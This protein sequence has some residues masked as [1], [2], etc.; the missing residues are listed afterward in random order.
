MKRNAELATRVMRALALSP[1]R[2]HLL[3][4]SA[5][6]APIVVA[7]PN[8]TVSVVHERALLASS[9]GVVNVVIAYAKQYEV[10]SFD[11]NLIADS[12]LRISEGLSIGMLSIRLH[13]NP[14]K[15][16]HLE[17]GDGAVTASSTSMFAYA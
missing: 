3:R 13:H 9:E 17:M 12:E 8:E 11:D 16:I 4:D 10:L 1:N 15:T 7:L 2:P 5:G 14:G 6:N